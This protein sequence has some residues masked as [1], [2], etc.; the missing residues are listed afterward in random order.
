MFVSFNSKHELL[1]STEHL[2]SPSDFS[3]FRVARSLVFCVMFY[4][5]FFVLCPLTIVFSVLLQFTDSDYPFGSFNL[6]LISVQL[7]VY[8]IHCDVY[9]IALLDWY[10]YFQMINIEMIWVR[11]WLLFSIIWAISQLSHVENKLHFRE[12]IMICTRPTH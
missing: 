11:E 2:S 12:M 3:G 7:H 9:H 6:S 5:S 1:T 4:W 8:Y 10:I